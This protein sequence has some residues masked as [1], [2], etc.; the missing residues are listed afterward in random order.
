MNPND[1]IHKTAEN[2]ARIWIR[3][4]SKVGSTSITTFEN[5]N[6]VSEM[7]YKPWGE[8]RYASGITPT[9]Y[10]FT[11]Q[12][13]HTADFG[14]MFYNARWY[15]PALGR[16]AQAD[17]IVPGGVQGLD[18][19]AYT[20][21]SPVNYIDPT[22]HCSLSG[23]WIPDEDAACQWSPPLSDRAQD[24][25]DFSK[26]IGM[27]PEDVI[28]I[29]LGHEWY[30][31]TGKDLSTAGKH[32][33][34]RFVDWGRSNCNGHLTHECMLNFFMVQYQSVQCLVYDCSIRNGK[35][36]RVHSKYWDPK[37]SMSFST[38]QDAPNYVSPSMNFAKIV[39]KDF[40]SSV[41]PIYNPIISPDLAYDTGVYLRLDM[42]KIFGSP[43]TADGT[44]IL[45][46]IA[47]RCSN[48]KKKLIQL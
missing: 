12:Y 6:L 26:I 47:S 16:F 35:L 31:F 20:N 8:E 45:A 29:G 27:T 39:M 37:N 14:L 42:A 40:W 28:A 46:I 32:V 17:T 4:K 18:R 13:S 48:G 9:D 36:N 41:D 22:G 1:C 2:C 38:D 25:V 23:H 19:Y 3:G 11:G 21:N 7:R 10:T 24:L 44:R 5:G 33:P 34:N 15:D 43:V 30:G